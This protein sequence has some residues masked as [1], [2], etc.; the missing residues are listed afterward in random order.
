MLEKQLE[1]YLQK[2]TK[3]IE[4]LEIN[5]DSLNRH[6]DDL[7]NELCVTPEQISLFIQ[8]RENFTEENWTYLS[9]EL[10]SLEVKLQRELANISNPQKTKKSF[11]ERNIQSHWL[12]VR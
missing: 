2:H 3:A 12:F 11:N 10:H 7:F 6:V 9:E 4:E 8:N 5:I 1:S